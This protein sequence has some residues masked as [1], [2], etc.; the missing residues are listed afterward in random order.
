MT[1]NEQIK[2]FALE[3]VGCAYIYGSTGQQ[4]T[5]SYR[6]ARMEQYPTYANKIAANCPALKNGT[7]DCS[8]CKYKG[9]KAYDC[10]QLTRHAAKSAGLELPSGASSQWNKANWAQ[11]GTINT[12]P[13]NIVCFL[14]SERK[15]SN[16]M[17]HTGIYLGDGTVVDSRGHAY[18]VVHRD[19]S[20][21]NWT[22]W[23]ILNGQEIDMDEPEKEGNTTKYVVTGNRLALRENPNLTAKLLLRMDTGTIVN[24]APVLNNWVKITYGGKTGYS[25]GEYLQEI[26]TVDAEEPEGDPSDDVKLDILWNWYQKQNQ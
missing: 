9:K 15:D 23:G 16:P 17:G 6:K 24:G 10:A 4:C 19:I 3:A 13:E 12:L 1:V 7:N 20:D 5:P 18:G 21:T 22:H 2:N 14:Y 11:K 26:I 8:G 25:C